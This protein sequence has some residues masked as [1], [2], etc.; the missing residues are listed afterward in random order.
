MK[1]CNWKPQKR[2][3]SAENYIF[4]WGKYTL[5]PWYFRV[6][7][8]NLSLE[9]QYHKH[10]KDWASVIIVQKSISSINTGAKLTN[11]EKSKNKEQPLSTFTD[12]VY[13]RLAHFPSFIPCS[14][15]HSQ[16]QQFSLRSSGITYSRTVKCCFAKMT[17]IPKEAQWAEH[18]RTHLNG[19]LFVH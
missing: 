17:K 10:F 2:N 3:R 5:S 6:F 9:T 8:T 15:Y 4:L 11:C 16:A 19:V 1:K 12:R 18:F 14:H 7:A 13:T